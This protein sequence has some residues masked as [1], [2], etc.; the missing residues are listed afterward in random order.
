MPGPGTPGQQYGYPDSS[1]PRYQPA[2]PGGGMA[3]GYP[4]SPV[5]IRET[6]VTGR[7]VVQYIIDY[8]LSGIIP[9]L[10]YWLFDRGHG[11]LHGFGWLLATVISLAVLLWYWVL[12]PHS[13]NGQTFGMQLLGVRVISKDGGPAN[14]VQLI[15]RTVLLII[16]D[17]V[18]GLVGLITMLCSRYR[19]RVGD[20]AARTLVVNATPWYGQNQRNY[21]GADMS[22]RTRV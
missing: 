17:L 12:R 19:Q 8:I 11:V 13:K 10:A 5:D 20:H 9:G 15:I 4:E 22:G 18:F 3:G 14:M 21:E 7:R 2:G 6:R 1:V 16:D